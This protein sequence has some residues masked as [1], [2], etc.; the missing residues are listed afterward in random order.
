MCSLV[1]H[2][3]MQ[4]DYEDNEISLLDRLIPNDATPKAL[5]KLVATFNI[6]LDVMHK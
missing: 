3:K 5:E 6:T 2:D 4:P 1:A